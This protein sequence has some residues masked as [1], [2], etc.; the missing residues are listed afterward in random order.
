MI[1]PREFLSPGAVLVRKEAA[2]DGWDRLSVEGFQTFADGAVEVV[3]RPADGFAAPIHV[4]AEALDAAYLVERD[5][6]PEPPFETPIEDALLRRDS[7]LT[8]VGDAER[9]LAE[10]RAEDGKPVGL[11]VQAWRRWQEQNTE[12]QEGN[13]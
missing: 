2:G 5:G 11:A 3:V 8:G 6:E 13:E 9:I 1:D 10:D 12:P 7:T 4:D